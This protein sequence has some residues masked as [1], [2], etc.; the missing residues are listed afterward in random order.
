M[1]VYNITCLGVIVNRKGDNPIQTGDNLVWVAGN[2]VKNGDC[3]PRATPR[4]LCVR[5]TT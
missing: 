1:I 5:L 2:L 4:V 3:H